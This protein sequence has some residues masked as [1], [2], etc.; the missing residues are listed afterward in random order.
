MKFRIIAYIL[1]TFLSGCATNSKIEDQDLFV[2][3]KP[4]R[5]PKFEL[6]KQEVQLDTAIV[7]YALK[8]GYGGRKYVPQDIF[9]KAVSEIEAIGSKELN[10][11]ELC[12]QIGEKLFLIPDMHLSARRNNRNCSTSARNRHAVGKVGPNHLRD[13]KKVWAIDYI[14]VKNKMVPLLSITSLPA[15]EDAAWDGFEKEIGKIKASASAVIIDMRGNGGGSDSRVHQLASYLFGQDCPTSAAAIV[16]SQTPATFALASNNP[17]SR[18][19]RLESKSES[20]PE[21]LVKDYN[22]KIQKYQKAKNR[23]LPEE[24]SVAP[25]EGK[26]FDQSKAFK[27]PILL[28][29]DRECASSCESAVETLKLHPHV[30]TMGENTGGYIHF[31][32]LGTLVLPNSGIV[33]QI[34]TDFWK[35]KDGRY[36]EGI[37]YEPKIAIKPGTDALVAAK[38]YLHKHLK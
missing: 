35:Y 13:E 14:K 11:D 24:I 18:M 3:D 12:S 17:K 4:I 25:D 37:G 31:G 38:D 21:Y 33:I 26:P 2:S 16:K 27:N 10:A 23:E 8:N 22:D 32:N 5:L 1:A 36:L 9:Q 29:V 30:V 34:A 15:Y 19:L 7:A 6:S 20:I 28:L